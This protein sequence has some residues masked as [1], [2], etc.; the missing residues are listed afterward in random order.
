MQKDEDQAV[1]EQAFQ[2]GVPTGGSEYFE[3]LEKSKT[4]SYD[5]FE[6][7]DVLYVSGNDPGKLREAFEGGWL[8]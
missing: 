1:Q 8:T 2:D 5:E 3:L 4:L 7:L 6:K